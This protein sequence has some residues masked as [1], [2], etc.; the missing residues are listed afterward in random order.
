MRTFLVIIF[1]VSATIKADR[2]YIFLHNIFL[3]NCVLCF[4]CHNSTSPDCAGDL[5]TCGTCMTEVTEL[6]SSNR[7]S[8][9][10]SV[11]KT[12]NL[13]ADVCNTTY[14]LNNDHVHNRI[15]VNCC[16][17]DYCN[18]KPLEVTPWNKTENG[19]ECPTCYSQDVE[20]CVANTTVKCTG[21]ENKC[22]D[23][24]GKILQKGVC[25]TVAFQGCATEL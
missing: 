15:T 22:L 5:V 25:Q 9:S 14:S 20:S 21:D 4:E 6:D 1:I 11:R 23:F 12:C 10:Y 24:K 19:L 8:S 18:E 3:G 7:N 17:T 16:D 2:P 13:N